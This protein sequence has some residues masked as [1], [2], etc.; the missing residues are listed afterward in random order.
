MAYFC[1]ADNLDGSHIGMSPKTQAIV[2]L[3]LD[4]LVRVALGNRL[5]VGTTSLHQILDF[6]ELG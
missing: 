1:C 5:L 2:H 3:Y 4:M 6:L